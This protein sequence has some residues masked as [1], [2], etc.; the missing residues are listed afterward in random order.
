MLY[1]Y[2]QAHGARGG[3]APLAKSVPPLWLQ[4]TFLGPSLAR[5]VARMGHG[6]AG[7]PCKVCAPLVASKKLFLGPLWRPPMVAFHIQYHIY[8]NIRLL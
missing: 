3:P 2:S 6:G 8:Y 7:P 4:K 5:P 1:Y